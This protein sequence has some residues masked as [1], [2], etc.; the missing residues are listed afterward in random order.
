MLHL[1]SKTRVLYFPA[2]VL[3]GGLT[4]CTTVHP[5][6]PDPFSG[7]LLYLQKTDIRPPADSSTAASLAYFG[8]G[9]NRE[10]QQDYPA[11]L[12]AFLE[13][14]RLDPENDTLYMIASR[15]LMVAGRKDDAFAL[16]DK[17]LV[18]QPDNL[19]ARRWLAK[20][21]LREGEIEKSKAELERAVAAHPRDEQIYI[22]L[23]QLLLKAQNLPEV[24][25]VARLAHT[26]AEKPVKC[27]EILAKLLVGELN[28]A[29]DIQTILALTQELNLVLQQA[30]RDFPAVESFAMLQARLAIEKDQWDVAFQS[31][32]NLDKH[33]NG[34]EE[35][36]ARMLVLAVRTA[37][38]PP[39][40][41]KRLTLAL[42]EG[43]PSPLTYYLLGLIKELAREPAE[44]MA[45]YEK[46]LDLAPEDFGAL[47]KLAILTYQNRQTARAAAL[48]DKVLASHPD[49][50]EVLLL[51]GQLSLG[52]DQ[53]ADA[54]RYLTRRLYRAKQGETLENPAMV[55]AQLAMA[56]LSWDGQ[57]EAAADAMV[58]AASE[59]GNLE[60]VWQFQIQK[61][62][63]KAEQDEKLADIEAEKF[64]HLLEDISD[65][66]PENPEIEWLIGR[67]HVYRKSYSDAVRAFERCGEIAALSPNPDLWLNEEFYFD[68][69]AAYERAGQIEKAMS[70]FAEI[71]KEHPNHHPSLN[72][73]AYMWAERAENLD[74]AL[75]HVKRALVLDPENGAYLD[76]LGWIY[77]QKQEYQ[78]AYRE[79]QRAAE[80]IPD[81]PVVTEHLGDVLMKL[82]R[83]WEAR[84]YY[85]ISLSLE[86]GE[87]TEFVQNALEKA[88][89]A[90]TDSLSGGRTQ[91]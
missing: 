69:A 24:L 32:E 64:L 67:S 21:Y 75:K 33:L 49:D 3:I 81:D 57:M 38:G 44:A 89:R 4:A 45:A 6:Q 83:P 40:G 23:I 28:Q 63:A 90:V 73:L 82:G 60:W 59:P 42:E 62:Y 55:Q 54:V 8:L 31:F 53:Y 41:V 68:L 10:L 87:R 70:L 78:A 35:T 11:A 29:N 7:E 48:L 5:P 17:L 46:A 14:I 16:L 27:T 79:L 43:N 36:R 58:N 19:T 91:L 74:D 61:I 9:L 80:V 12:D 47:R 18:L 37:G 30:I 77:Y 71:I 25:E 22:E 51:A 88:D 76:T 85:R 56:L 66:L 20:L 1:I 50:P 34:N 86:P 84:A 2:L 52:A 13:A 26:H 72:Y 65:R 39:N 15:R